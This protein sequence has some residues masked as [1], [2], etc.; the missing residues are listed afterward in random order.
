MGLISSRRFLALIAACSWFPI[1]ASALITVGALDTPSYAVGVEVVDNLAYVVEE[2]WLWTPGSLRIIDV[3]DP[4]SPVELGALATPDSAEDVEVVGGLAYVV[5]TEFV[6][7][8][9]PSPVAPPVR[10]Y[11]GWLRVIDVSDPAFPVEVGFFDTG[12]AWRGSMNVE[13]VGDVAYVAAGGAGLHIVDVSNP[14]FPVEIGA[15]DTLDYSNRRLQPR[16]PG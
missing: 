13:V 14:A 7:S 9:P 10:F 1:G 11:A 16:L 6:A 5:G 12:T 3:S 8:S 15:L 2:Q 4:A